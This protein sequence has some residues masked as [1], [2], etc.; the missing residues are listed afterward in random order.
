M[1]WNLCNPWM[2]HRHNDESYGIASQLEKRGEAAQLKNHTIS[3]AARGRSHN[4]PICHPYNSGTRITMVPASAHTKP[5]SLLFSKNKNMK[6]Q[7]YKKLLFL[8][9]KFKLN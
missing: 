4:N 6:E 8:F 3:D 9:E 5:G 7:L 1:L 2:C